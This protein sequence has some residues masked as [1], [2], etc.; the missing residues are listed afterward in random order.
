MSNV[1]MIDGHIDDNQMTPEKAIKFFNE[2]IRR[3]E[4][5]P[6]INGCKMTE[7]WAEQLEICKTA[8]SA[9][10]KQMPKFVLVSKG[11]QG[12][13]DTRYYCPFCNSLTRQHEKC[14][15]KC[16]QAVKYPKEVYDKEKN[17]IVLDWS[18]T[19]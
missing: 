16:G 18:D 10:E 13:R 17:K 3:L 4:L 8:K 6:K 1:S 15:H 14:C 9:I 2:E 19:E 12:V 11:F 7:E 5:A